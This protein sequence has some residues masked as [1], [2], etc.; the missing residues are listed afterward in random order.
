MGV[1]EGTHID[2]CVKS[3]IH[4]HNSQICHTGN[5]SQPGSLNL[6]AA[7]FLY[8][9]ICIGLNYRVYGLVPT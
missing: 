7:K 5:V 4:V 6:L 2:A 1:K 8:L 9:Q 3:Y